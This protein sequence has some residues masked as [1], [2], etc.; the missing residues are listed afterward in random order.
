MEAKSLKL[1]GYNEIE[2]GAQ[3]PQK[4]LVSMPS[5]AKTSA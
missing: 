3:T 2:R 1:H 5:E 4:T